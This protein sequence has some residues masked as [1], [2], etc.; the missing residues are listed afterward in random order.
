LEPPSPAKADVAPASDAAPAS[1]TKAAEGAPAS[2]A[3]P[4]SNST[5]TSPTKATEVASN[6]APASPAKPADAAQEASNPAPASPAKPP[7]NVNDAIYTNAEAASKLLNLTN[8]DILVRGAAK[9]KRGRKAVGK[10]NDDLLIEKHGLVAAVVEPTTPHATFLYNLAP[11][12]QV[13]SGFSPCYLG[14][15]PPKKDIVGPDVGLIVT[16]SVARFIQ[17]NPSA[18]D[19]LG[20]DVNIYVYTVAGDR[21]SASVKQSDG[22]LLA[23]KLAL[24][25]ERKATTA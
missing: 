19:V 8:F 7:S 25:C 1:P 11:N 2:E 24:F 10:S 3:S 4:A 13:Y 15:L 17:S 9:K 14:G 20:T 23:S 6:P 22:K 12:L 18:L 5:P 21:G 16:R